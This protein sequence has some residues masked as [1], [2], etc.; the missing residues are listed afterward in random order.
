MQVCWK[1]VHARK[2]SDVFTMFNSIFTKHSCRGAS[3]NPL[4]PIKTRAG[5]TA[6]NLIGSCADKPELAR[7]PWNAYQGKTTPTAESTAVSV[8]KNLGRM[9][10]EAVSNKPVAMPK[11]SPKRTT[12]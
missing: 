5:E 7:A 9:P 10:A 12:L 3:C 1:L 6:E 11:P 2:Y 4:V 8:V